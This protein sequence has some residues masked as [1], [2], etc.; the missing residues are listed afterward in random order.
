MHF[1]F[2]TLNNKSNWEFL[3]IFSTNLQEFQFQ[4]LAI[5][6]LHGEKKPRKNNEKLNNTKISKAVKIRFINPACLDTT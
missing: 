6:D 2:S 4:L 3:Q 5:K 1:I